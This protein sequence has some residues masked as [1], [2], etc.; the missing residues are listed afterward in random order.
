MLHAAMEQRL[1][2]AVLVVYISIDSYTYSY[3]SI[4]LGSH[5]DMNANIVHNGSCVTRQT[6]GVRHASWRYDD[7]C[8][9]V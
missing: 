5:S 1:C 7:L 9:I 2:Y 4:A 3:I 8:F 6:D